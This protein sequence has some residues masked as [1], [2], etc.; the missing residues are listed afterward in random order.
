MAAD[1]A[2]LQQE[3]FQ[4]QETFLSFVRQSEMVKA[5]LQQSAA[6]NRM[7]EITLR[8]LAQI[9]E[10]PTYRTVGKSYALQPHASLVAQMEADIAK[11][12]KDI[13]VLT[14]TDKYVDKKQAEAE[15]KLKEILTQMQH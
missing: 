11:T 10:A 14:S 6:E 8:A 4:A 15:E 1:K 5:Q 9:P 7:R 2:A 13:A 3:L 12:S